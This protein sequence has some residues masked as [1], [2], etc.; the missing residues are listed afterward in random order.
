MFVPLPNPAPV[1]S[2][3]PSCLRSPSKQV[4]IANHPVH[5]GGQE[6]LGWALLRR[7][8]RACYAHPMQPTF[9][10][11]QMIGHFRTFGPLGPAYRVL[12]PIR[13]TESEDWLLRIEVVETGEKA[14]YPYAQAM[15]DP[16]IG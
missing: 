11:P 2:T 5:C 8:R 13:K 4:V 12:E 3:W 9:P 1:D 16:E 10:S 15:N 7:R 6:C 14:E